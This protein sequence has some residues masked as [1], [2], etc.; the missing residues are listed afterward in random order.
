MSSQPSQMMCDT[1]VSYGVNR[2]T[3][4]SSMSSM[5]SSSVPSHVDSA[6]SNSSTVKQV[7]RPDSA[8]ATNNDSI[9]FKVKRQK[10][11][12]ANK[13]ATT[14]PSNLTA[15]MAYLTTSTAVGITSKMRLRI[16]SIVSC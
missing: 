7:V 1:G 4:K 6:I 3:I 16:S 2:S 15:G 8:R 12:L 13:P 10:P 11:V 9:T 5:L 14:V